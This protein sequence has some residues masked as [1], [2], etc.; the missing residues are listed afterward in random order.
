M[1]LQDPACIVLTMSQRNQRHYVGIIPT[2]SNA[3]GKEQIQANST[4]PIEHRILSRAE[5]AIGTSTFDIVEFYN[6]SSISISLAKYLRLNPK[7]LDKLVQ[8]V[9][10]DSITNAQFTNNMIEN[11]KTSSEHIFI[12]ERYIKNAPYRQPTINAIDGEIE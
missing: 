11:P 3:K 6:S 2:L 1:A 4:K 7:E 5:S 10:G 8:Y 12:S 9:K